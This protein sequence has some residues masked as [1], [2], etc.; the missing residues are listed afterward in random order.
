MYRV[1]SDF[2]AFYVDGEEKAK[3]YAQNG[4]DV[5]KVIKLM[6]DENDEFVSDE[7]NTSTNT[8]GEN[9]G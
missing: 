5:Y 2:T 4:Y 9:N 1:V 3:R 6:L 7:P 8:A